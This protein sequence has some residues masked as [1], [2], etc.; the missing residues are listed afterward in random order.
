MKKHSIL[1]ASAAH[2]WI[3]CPYSVWEGIDIPDTAN[4][5]AEEGTKA[6]IL[7]ENILLEREYKIDDFD[8][9]MFECARA[10]VQ[11]V[12]EHS[13]NGKRYIEQRIDYSNI[14]GVKYINGELDSFGTA[15]CVIEKDDEIIVIDFKYGKGVRVEVENNPQ[16]MLYA[17]GCLN[18]RPDIRKFT[19]CIFQPRLDHISEWSF[20][21]DNASDF[22]SR[23]KS[24]AADVESQSFKHKAGEHC[25]FCKIAGACSVRRAYFEENVLRDFEERESAIMRN[26]EIEQVL[27]YLDDMEAW[28]K[29]VRDEAFN[30]AMRGEDFKFFKLVK[31]REG[32]RKWV[33]E[34]WIK[35]RFGKD[36]VKEVV[37][38][39]TEFEKVFPKKSNK[40]LW[41]D[42]D[43]QITRSQ[44]NPVL[45]SVNDK[46]DRFVNNPEDD[47]KNL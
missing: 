4:E 6:H 38:S 44:G 1:S 8:D 32:N 34:S 42:I 22:I 12:E 21:L 29:S 28:V 30:R 14:T 2:R 27:L 43:Q 41:S 11:Y 10:Y 31:G 3:E 17:L 39:P 45:V 5:F 9:E 24:A 7:C 20:T 16:L 33:D 40:E 13:V 23:V 35:D 18:Q 19:I 47:L 26:A 46:R 25:R 36:A 15:D 37:L